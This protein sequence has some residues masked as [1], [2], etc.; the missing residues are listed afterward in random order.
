MYEIYFFFSIFR[1]L[2]G[3]FFFLFSRKKYDKKKELE[4]LSN[5]LLQ[6]QHPLIFLRILFSFYKDLLS[7]TIIWTL[8][9]KK[10]FNKLELWENTK[11]TVMNTYPLIL[12]KTESWKQKK[13][14]FSMFLSQ[15]RGGTGRRGIFLQWLAWNSHK[16]RLIIGFF[17]YL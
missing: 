15:I 3:Y 12:R 16:G 5:F 7:E 14:V 9:V 8:S 11:S 13:S 4:N 2:E 10:K 17:S 6:V 1:H